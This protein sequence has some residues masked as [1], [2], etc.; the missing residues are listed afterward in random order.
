MN[1]R[2]RPLPPNVKAELEE[3]LYELGEREREVMNLRYGLRDDK[4]RWLNE[5]ASELNITRDRVRFIE[6]KALD[7]LKSELKE[8][9]KML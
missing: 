6:N 8:V 7:K 3:A 2:K 4:R 5:V 1:E 9:L